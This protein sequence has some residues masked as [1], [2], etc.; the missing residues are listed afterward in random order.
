MFSPPPS[1]SLW[2][3]ARGKSGDEFLR[4]SAKLASGGWRDIPLRCTGT[5]NGQM[6]RTNQ[7]CTGHFDGAPTDVE[8]LVFEYNDDGS[9][10]DVIIKDGRVMFFG[11][12]VWW[13]ANSSREDA[14]S[15]NVNGLLWFL[16]AGNLNWSGIQ[17]YIN[18]SEYTSA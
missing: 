6:R 3:E 1:T 18:T 4:I 15:R 16:R 7:V 13:E 2:L 17:A 5:N 8:L 9:R 14:I 12:N 10:N 11:V